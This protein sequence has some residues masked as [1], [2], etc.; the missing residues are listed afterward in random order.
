MA[1]VQN[2]IPQIGPEEL[3]RR[4]DAGEDVFVL[5]VREPHEYQIAKIGGHLIPLS[6][7]PKRS[8]N[9][10]RDEEHRG[11]VQV[12]RAQPAGGGVPGA[13]RLHEGGQPG[14]RHHGVV[15]RRSTRRCRS[16]R[17]WQSGHKRLRREL[18]GSLRWSLA[19]GVAGSVSVNS[20][21]LRCAA[22]VETTM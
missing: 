13:A 7:L 21:S 3:K 22:P 11:A 2:G 12:R 8:A 18:M 1:N 19:F 20:R 15:G 4:L 10:I 5:D 14:G 16:T 9:W 6:E 17:D